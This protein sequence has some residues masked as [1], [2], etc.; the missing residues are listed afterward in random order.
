MNYQI[1]LLEEGTEKGSIKFIL[2]EKF[3]DTVVMVREI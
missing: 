3:Q 2:K 1:I